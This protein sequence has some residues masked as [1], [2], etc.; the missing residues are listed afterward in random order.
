M[1]GSYH[2]RFK[3]YFEREVAEKAAH[4]LSSGAEI[5]IQILD[6]SLKA[7]ETLTL[8]RSGGKNV[9]LATPAQ[10]PQLVFLTPVAAAES[11]LSETSQDIAM[12]GIN[13][14]KLVTS[15]EAER[16]L[17]I[18]FKAGFL[19]LFSKGYLGVLTAGGSSMAQ[20]LASKGLNGIGSINA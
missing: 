5:E 14:L 13:I 17:R 19:S 2:E 6:S 18:Q 7:V 15:T 10:S 1:P 20:Y 8:T 16:R 9:V 3:A 12:I 4:S 11:I